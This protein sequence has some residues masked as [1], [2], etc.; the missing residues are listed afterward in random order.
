MTTSPTTSGEL[1]K[2]QPGIFLP[3]SDAALRDQTTEPLRA[4]SAFRMP[5]APNV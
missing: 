1:A 5:V 3:V 2:P 4:S